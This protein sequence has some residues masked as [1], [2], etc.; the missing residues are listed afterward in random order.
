MVIFNWSL[1]D[2]LKLILSLQN[3]FVCS[4]PSHKIIEFWDEKLYIF[5]WRTT[6][7]LT[8]MIGPGE[9]SWLDA[10]RGRDPNRTTTPVAASETVLLFLDENDHPASCHSQAVELIPT[11]GQSSPGCVASRLWASP[12][13]AWY[14]AHAVSRHAKLFTKTGEIFATF[15]GVQW[16]RCKNGQDFFWKRWNLLMHSLTSP[17]VV[18]CPGC[19]MK[20]MMSEGLEAIKKALCLSWIRFPSG[21]VCCALPYYPPIVLQRHKLPEM[22]TKMDVHMFLLF[23]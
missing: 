16:D 4:N 8:R 1:I 14:R 21:Q 11:G 17:H 5:P 12:V 10:K 3:N 19:K 23:A 18:F 22:V 13:P 20:R 7:I 6:E 2:I 9:E 15:D